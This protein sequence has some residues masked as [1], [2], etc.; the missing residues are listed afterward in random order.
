[1]T[2]AHEQRITDLESETFRIGHRLDRLAGGIEHLT[3]GV[4]DL[5]QEQRALALDVREAGGTLTDQ[6]TR[7]ERIEQTIIGHGE[8][9]RVILDRLSGQADARA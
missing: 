1:M 2:A 9:L 7:L 3:T 5:S 4:G 8:L 6:S